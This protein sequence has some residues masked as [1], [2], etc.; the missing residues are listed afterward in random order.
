MF[1][2]N[3]KA[4]KKSLYGLLTGLTLIALPNRAEGQFRKGTAIIFN[5]V[6][7]TNYNLTNLKGDPSLSKISIDFSPIRYHLWN[8]KGVG[9]HIGSSL[10]FEL[11]FG[12]NFYWLNTPYNGL[13]YSLGVGRSELIYPYLV[14]E[15]NWKIRAYR[16]SGLYY[17]FG[18]YYDYRHLYPNPRKNKD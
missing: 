2:K 6:R 16:K 7:D 12:L 5:V 14:H 8:N 1:S 10:N 3:M 18:M 17:S 4:I 9:L 11:E 13:G 15:Q